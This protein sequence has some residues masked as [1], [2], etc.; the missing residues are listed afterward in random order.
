MCYDELSMPALTIDLD[1]LQ[2]NLD[3]MASSCRQ[4]GVGL[5]PHTKMHKTP[6]VTRLQL[7]SGALGLTVAP[8]GHP[9]SRLHVREHAR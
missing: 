2:R 1:T 9:Q 8:D 6:E 5:R 4:Q 7:E 3:R